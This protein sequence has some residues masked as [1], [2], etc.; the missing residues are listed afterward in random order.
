MSK[1]LYIT[2]YFTELEIHFKP[3]EHPLLFAMLSAWPKN[4]YLHTEGLPEAPEEVP[5]S[6]LLF[7][8]SLLLLWED[9]LSN[10]RFHLSNCNHSGRLLAFGTAEINSLFEKTLEFF[11][12]VGRK[13]PVLLQRLWHGTLLLSSWLQPMPATAAKSYSASKASCWRHGIY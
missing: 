2:S 13:Q 4:H 9:N 7:R 3:I 12:A 1:I 5:A 11:V 6:L 8:L 10:R